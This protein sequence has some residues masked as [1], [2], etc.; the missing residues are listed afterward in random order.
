MGNSI[1]DQDFDHRPHRAGVNTEPYPT[2][3]IDEHLANAPIPQEWYDRATTWELVKHSFQQVTARDWLGGA[4]VVLGF[5]IL[6]S[7]LT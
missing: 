1:K 5:L 7:Y 3:D 4:C 6:Y 2:V